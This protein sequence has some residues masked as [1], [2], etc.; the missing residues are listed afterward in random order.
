MASCC[1]A[2]VHA[3]RVD[4]RVDV[5]LW[6]ITL[7]LLLIPTLTAADTNYLLLDVRTRQIIKQDWPAME[8]PIPVGSL[9]KPFLALAAAGPL[10]EFLCNGKIDHCWL[11]KGHGTLGF[12]DAL[13]NSCN[14]YFLQLAKDVDEHSLAVIAASFG[15]PP[16]DAETPEARIGLGTE[17]KISPLAIAR[18]YCELTSRSAEPRVAEILAGMKLAAE[19]GTASAIGRGALAKTGT[20]SCVANRKHRGDGFTIILAPADAPRIV[21]LVRVHGVPGAE[22]AKFAAAILRR[23][24][25]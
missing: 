16:P 20:A 3:C 22:A 14:A 13:A 10:P 25:P 21:L 4:I 24:I 2:R 12:R 11:A 15:I 19:S 9:V 5:R 8:T 7:L 6:T 18:A 23:E 17:W 1:G